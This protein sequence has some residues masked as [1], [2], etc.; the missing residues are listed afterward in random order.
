[1]VHL[2]SLLESAKNGHGVLDGRLS[3][4]D[5]L[6]STF[7][8][9]VLFDVLSILVEGRCT[10]QAKFASCEQGFDHVAR[11]H[12]TFGRARSHDRV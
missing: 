12:R 11:V 2:V 7:E 6:E 3:H 8:S 9:G 10:N 1:M 5:L 4:E